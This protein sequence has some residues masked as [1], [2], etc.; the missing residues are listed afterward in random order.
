[1]GRGRTRYMGGLAFCQP[2]P[3][4]PQPQSPGRAAPVRRYE[5]QHPGELIHIDVKK[6]CR[7]DGV[8]HRI[9]GDR[10][11]QS[12]RRGPGGSNAAR[13]QGARRRSQRTQRGPDVLVGAAV[14]QI[15]KWKQPS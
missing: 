15:A 12:N 13:Y 4:A 14:G 8:G 5:R 10:R 3:Q 7:I 2:H 1:M 6:L 9:T 11:G